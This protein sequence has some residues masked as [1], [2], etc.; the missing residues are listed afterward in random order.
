[1]VPTERAR[2]VAAVHTAGAVARTAGIAAVAARRVRTDGMVV[3]VVP[4][5]D[6]VRNTE[7][8]VVDSTERRQQWRQP[9]VDLQYR[10]CR[11]S[12]R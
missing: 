12:G 10:T 6:V 3:L 11:R 8:V 9:R 4:P 1:M 5:D 7:S 2:A